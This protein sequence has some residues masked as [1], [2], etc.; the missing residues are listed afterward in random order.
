MGDDDG[1]NGGKLVIV[2]VIL[3]PTPL[4]EEA[5]SSASLP[6]YLSITQRMI[7][8]EE[9]AKKQRGSA[10]KLVSLLVHNR[11]QPQ[12]DQID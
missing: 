1:G 10:Q 12:L 4:L 11:S 9:A 7:P 6:F 2:M 5:G 3:L 8:S